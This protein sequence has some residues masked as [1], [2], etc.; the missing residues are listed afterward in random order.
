MWVASDSGS[1][2]FEAAI[3]EHRLVISVEGVEVG[4]WPVEAVQ[5]QVEPEGIHL[6]LGQD[7]VVIDV[8]DRVGLMMA[9]GRSASE[10]PSRR[11]RNLPSLRLVVASVLLGALVVASV[12]ATGIVGSSLLILG[13]LVLVLGAFATSEPRLAL[14][15]PFGLQALHVVGVGVGLLAIGMALV[16]VA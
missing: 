2:P 9:L 16:A 8:T 7:E 15:L 10:A 13:L 4:N 3:A 5:A 11:Q 6:R 1:V 14:R 12:F